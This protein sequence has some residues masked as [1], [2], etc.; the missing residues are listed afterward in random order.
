MHDRLI[1]LTAKRLAATIVTKD[2]TI[3]ASPQVKW[4]W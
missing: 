1:A 4:L 2:R 3:Q